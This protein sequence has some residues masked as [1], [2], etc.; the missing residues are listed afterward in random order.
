MKTRF[1]LPADRVLFVCGLFLAGCELYKQVFLYIVINGGRYDWWYFP[2]QLCS[3]PVYLCLL[4]PY[5]R[6][7]PLKTTAYT[8][9]QDY[10]MLGGIAALLVPDGF[11][12]LHWTLTLH[13]YV[14]HIMLIL[15][16]LFIRATAQSDRSTSGFLRTLPL[17]ACFCLIATLINLLAP[18]CGE[19]DMFY[20][21]PYYPTTQ[22]V[23]HEIALRIGILPGNLFYLF[24]VCLGAYLIHRILAFLPGHTAR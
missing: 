11:R 3:L 2:F 14:W 16:A 1:P 4:M 7:G 10:G 20:I 23:F 8:F 22:P 19:A 21:S 17:F 13:G 12:H 5:F 6:E 18:G 15:I 9:L 24:C